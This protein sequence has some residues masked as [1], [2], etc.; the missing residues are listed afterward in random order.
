MG[1][2]LNRR[3][4][5]RNSAM[6]SA[7]LSVGASGAK[8]A[9][10]RIQI[11]IIGTG[12]RGLGLAS[13]ISQIDEFDLIA[14]CDI[15]PDH[16]TKGMAYALPTASSYQDYRKMLENKDLDAVVIASPLYLHYEMALAAVD[17][18]K[19]VYCEKT[20]TH[21]TNEAI[22]LTKKVR[23]SD[24]VFQVGFQYRY[25]PLYDAIYEGIQAGDIGELKHF[26]CHYYRNN[27]WR[28][29][30]S[31]P[32]LE[33]TINWRMYRAYSGGVAAEL[34]A[35]QIDVINRLLDGHPVKI[36]GFGSTNTYQD[37]REIFD[38]INLIFEYPQ[39]ITGHVS[40]HLSNQHQPYIIKLMGTKGTVEIHRDKAF[41]Y[42]EPTLLST[43]ENKGIVDGV[44]G[45]TLKVEPGKAWQIPVDLKE[46]WSA[47][48]YALRGFA[49]SIKHDAPV[50]SNVRTGKDA[51][52]AVDMANNAMIHHRIEK[53]QDTYNIS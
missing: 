22:K 14:C 11:G 37:G 51:S 12:S 36:T 52:I 32:S 3:T 35:H 9:S 47:T 24:I 39:Q 28:R 23:E 45:A 16:L 33:R 53:W 38:N 4:F 50:K 8:R 20:M 6:A 19:H 40:C 10:E 34:S 30:V 25:Y 49:N 42:A 21:H 7:A 18:N 15:R 17:A 1:T 44:S 41:Y 29:P 26:I 48:T 5:I 31:D 46:G 2:F 13:E 27:D 43:T